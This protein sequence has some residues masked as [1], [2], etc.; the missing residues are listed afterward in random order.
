MQLL[1]LWNQQEELTTFF[2]LFIVQNLGRG[3]GMLEAFLSTGRSWLGIF[4]PV[5]VLWDEKSVVR[6]ASK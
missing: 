3:V 4:F 2:N 5:V 6:K 1:L